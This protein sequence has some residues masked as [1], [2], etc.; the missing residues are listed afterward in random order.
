VGG[1]A[2]SLSPVELGI[3]S[4][5]ARQSPRV[6]STEELVSEIWG[7]D[8]VSQET[9]DTLRSHIYHVRLKI[10]AVTDREVIRTVRG[11]GY[12]IDE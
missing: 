12:V 3:L 2:L 5:L 11:V 4:Y 8:I 9:A 1:A 6:V 7:Y 10:R